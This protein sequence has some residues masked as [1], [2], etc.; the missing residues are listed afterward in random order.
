VCIVLADITGQLITQVGTAEDAAPAE[1]AAL[2]GGSFSAE[3]GLARQ[4][5]EERSFNL[6]YHEGVRFD[7][8][9]ANVG[10]QLFLLL[11]FDRRMGA[12]RISMVWLYTKRAIQDL[13][14]LVAGERMLDTTEVLSPEF[15]A[16][17]A[18]RLDLLFRSR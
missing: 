11:L 2:L 10:D 13:L 18:D 15:S 8:Y 12:S 1:L 14:P 16:S 17:L 6:R 4:L 7:L 9:A 5:R 3:F